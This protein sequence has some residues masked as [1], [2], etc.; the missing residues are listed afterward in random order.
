MLAAEAVISSIARRRARGHGA[1]VSPAV[2]RG[3]SQP[4]PRAA[5]L[6]DA[7]LS[8]ETWRTRMVEEETR[9]CVSALDNASLR[10]YRK[11][12]YTPVSIS[13]PSVSGI[14]LF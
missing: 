10:R 4:S 12:D 14:A 3:G 8:A 5:G 6:G 7:G 13:Q 11:K 1:I 2:S 9:S